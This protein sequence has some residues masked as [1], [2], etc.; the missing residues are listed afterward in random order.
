MSRP[1]S[2][3]LRADWKLS[4][5]APIA[6]SVDLMLFDP[7]AQKPRYGARSLLVAALLRRWMAE[8]NG[9]PLPPVPSVGELRSLD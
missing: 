1:R 4:L 2:P 9:D 3:H 6:A 7:L 5:P 8:Q